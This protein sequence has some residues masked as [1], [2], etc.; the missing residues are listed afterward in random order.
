MPEAFAEEERVRVKACTLGFSQGHVGW[1]VYH[2]FG[3]VPHNIREERWGDPFH[4]H[5]LE[6]DLEPCVEWWIQ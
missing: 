3:D 4:I 6:W 1:V 2:D 5:R